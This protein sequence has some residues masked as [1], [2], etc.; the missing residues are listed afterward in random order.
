MASVQNSTNKRLLPLFE[1]LVELDDIAAEDDMIIQDLNDKCARFESLISQM[2]I[3]HRCLFEN[4][5]SKLGTERSKNAFGMGGSTYTDLNSFNGGGY[6]QLQGFQ[7]HQMSQESH[8][9]NFP[10]F[11]PMTRV[12]DG[13]PSQRSNSTWRQGYSKESQKV[14]R[15]SSRKKSEEPYISGDYSSAAGTPFQTNQFKY[16]SGE[17]QNQNPPPPSPHPK[18]PAPVPPAL[19]IN[20]PETPKPT[21]KSLFRPP[22]NSHNS[23]SQNTKKSQKTASNPSNKPT[24]LST[25]PSFGEG[26]GEVSVEDRQ[27]MRTRINNII[28]YCK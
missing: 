24:N 27:D 9:N 13:V 16:H 10:S 1:K 25:V 8:P 2:Q 7:D 18:S 28:K 17:S 3:K 20:L 14:S 12:Y 26:G 19:K 23:N 5:Q 4:Y 15:N 6:S 21:S 22:S 11:S